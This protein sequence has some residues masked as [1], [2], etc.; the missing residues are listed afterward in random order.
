MR[1]VGKC[2]EAVVNIKVD[3]VEVVDNCTV[4]AWKAGKEGREFAGMFDLGAMDYIYVTEERGN[5]R[6]E[7]QM[8][9]R[10]F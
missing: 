9:V 2:K 8:A 6:D 5:G 10:G 7:M 4:F 3:D 1:L